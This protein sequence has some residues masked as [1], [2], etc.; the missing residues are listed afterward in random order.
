MICEIA[1]IIFRICLSAPGSVFFIHPR[2][3]TQRSFRPQLQLPQQ[4]CRLHR[5]HYT[6]AIVDP[7]EISAWFW[8]ALSSTTTKVSPHTPV[9]EARGRTSPLPCCV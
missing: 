7:D 8:A 9:T 4:L 5:H 3:Y 6:R 1:L 2:N